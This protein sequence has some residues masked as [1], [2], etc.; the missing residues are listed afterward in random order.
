MNSKVSI[1]L[2]VL[3][4]LLAAG[5]VT[6]FFFVKGEMDNALLKARPL[7]QAAKTSEDPFEYKNLSNPVDLRAAMEI[8]SPAYKEIEGR[9]EQKRKDDAT[10]SSLKRSLEERDMKIASLNSEIDEK[11]AE[12]AELSRE[13]S[14]LESKVAGLESDLQTAEANLRSEKVTTA[15]LNER[16]ANMKT[17]EEYNAR[18]DEIANL[19]KEKE[20]G[21]NRYFK[22]RRLAI[23]NE[24]GFDEN[25]FPAGLYDSALPSDIPTPKFEA[26]YIL[27]SVISV[28][29]ERGILVVSGAF[30]PQKA[31]RGQELRYA[32]SE[33][34]YEV[35]VESKD[36]LRGDAQNIGSIKLVAQKGATTIAHVLPGNSLVDSVKPG[37]PLKIVPLGSK[38]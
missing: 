2:R 18:L 22:L 23:A 8:V 33:G 4:I 25:E 19:E 5:A 9:R 34:F 35:Y 10:I 12:N 26:P 36:S 38:R 24:V 37:T 11:N 27:T 15:A 6:L 14:D 28:D 32:D 29:K 30:L 3:A 17:L 21:Q 7:I 20:G 13:K 31:R 1:V 16:I